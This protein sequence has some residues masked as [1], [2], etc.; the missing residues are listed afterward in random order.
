M[1]IPTPNTWERSL[2]IRGNNKL[3]WEE[4]IKSHALPYLATLRNLSNIL[5]ANI[6]DSVL[7]IVAQKLVDPKQVE[8][9]KIFPIQYLSAI[10][11]MNE[12]K[13]LHDINQKI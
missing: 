10:E 4:L 9:S 2:S 11:S 1:K 5:K 13:E 8:N 12:L 3:A 7:E 6:S